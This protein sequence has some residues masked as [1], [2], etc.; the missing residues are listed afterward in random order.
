MHSDNQGTGFR[1]VLICY[2]STYVRTTNSPPPPPPA[3]GSPSLWLNMH[4]QLKRHGQA[5]WFD[6]PRQRSTIRIYILL[7]V[8]SRSMM[9]AFAVPPPSQI[10]CRPYRP[11]V[12]SSSWSRVVL[13]LAPVPPSG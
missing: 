3:P 10:A 5:A 7:P 12:R 1:D 2:K 8:G 6:A 9:V 11:P 4:G 13:S